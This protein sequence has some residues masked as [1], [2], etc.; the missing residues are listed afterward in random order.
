ML[1]C[2]WLAQ[3]LFIIACCITAC[4]LFGLGVVKAKLKQV[5]YKSGCEVLG[6]GGGA[7]AIACLVGA[8]VEGMVHTS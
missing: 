2:G 7:A 4:A 3:V 8:F 1:L 5:W 6:L